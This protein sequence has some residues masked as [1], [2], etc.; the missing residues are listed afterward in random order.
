ML[1]HVDINWP[2]FVPEYISD[3]IAMYSRHA[4]QRAS[5]KGINLPVH[6][7]GSLFECEVIDGRV[8]K[9]AVR[10]RYSN[11]HDLCTVI[12]SNGVIITVWLNRIDDNHGTLDRSKYV[13]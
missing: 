8:V 4:L 2:S 5:E 10:T 3:I 1:Y 6:I 7:S 13:A 9:V 11:T 12:G